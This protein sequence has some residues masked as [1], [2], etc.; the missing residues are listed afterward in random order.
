[1]PS[2]APLSVLSVRATPKAVEAAIGSRQWTKAVQ[3]L[4][5]Q[6]SDMAVRYYKSIRDHY[7]SVGEYEVGP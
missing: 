1:M 4:E 5:L 2:V 6:D 3:I 7:S